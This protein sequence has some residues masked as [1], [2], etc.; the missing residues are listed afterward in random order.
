VSCAWRSNGGDA[1]I[2]PVIPP[3]TKITSPASANTSGV[4][5]SG[6]P[7]QSVAS[8]PT[9]CTPVGMAM[10]VLAAAK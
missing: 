10:T 3:T 5:H 9:T 4:R 6:R 1:T 8:Q 2:T 7:L